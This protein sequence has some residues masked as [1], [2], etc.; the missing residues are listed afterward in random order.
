MR[1]ISLA[2]GAIAASLIAAPALAAPMPITGNWK[3][4]DGTSV[5]TFY[6]CGEAMC[7][8]IDRFLVAE[9]SG[10]ILDTKNPDKSKRNDKLV[11]KRIFWGL[12]PEGTSFEGKGYSPKDGRYFSADISR[13]G[14][15]LKVKGCVSIFCRTMTFTKF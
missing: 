15:K 11:G 12:T 10:G 9:P 5:I 14:A 1:T 6:K 13:D 4:D 7:G 3:T 8:K 2:F